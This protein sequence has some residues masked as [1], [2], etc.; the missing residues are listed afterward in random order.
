MMM[1]VEELIEELMSLPQDFNVLVIDTARPSPLGWNFK[2]TS[3]YIDIDEDAKIVH[4]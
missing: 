2:Y 4:L 3:P 1:T